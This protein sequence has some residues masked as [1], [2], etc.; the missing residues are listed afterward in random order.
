MP[1]TLYFKRAKNFV[2]SDDNGTKKFLAQPGPTPTPV[3]FWVADTPTFKQGIK[4]DSIVNLTPPDQMPGYKHPHH[5]AEEERPKEE[6]P[7]PVEREKTANELADEAEEAAAEQTELPK[8]QFGAQPMT[9]VQAGPKVGGI[10]G[11]SK[12]K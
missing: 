1:M 8:A 9:P 11:N 5:K 4:D 3:P 6:A 7:K 12:K 10:T 2:Q